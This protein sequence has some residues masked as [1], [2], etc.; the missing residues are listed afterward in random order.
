MWPCTTADLSRSVVSV[1]VLTVSD[2]RSMALAEQLPG[3]ISI[4]H[5]YGVPYSPA[6]A[7]REYPLSG[8][9]SVD[10]TP[11]HPLSGG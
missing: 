2:T 11:F 10:C 7:A 8:I 1:F 3:Y 5:T 4:A 9:P 6:V